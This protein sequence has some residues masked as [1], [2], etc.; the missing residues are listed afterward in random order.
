MSLPNLPARCS[1]FF[2]L[3]FSYSHSPTPIWAVV[4]EAFQF[5]NNTTFRFFSVG[6]MKSFSPHGVKTRREKYRF[7]RQNRVTK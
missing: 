4:S 1:S 7:N 3:V 6:K 5:V 2:L